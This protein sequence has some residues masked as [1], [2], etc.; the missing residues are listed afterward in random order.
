[1]HDGGAVHGCIKY[2]RVGREPLG[3]GV[4][5]CAIQRDLRERRRDIFV[6][7]LPPGEYGLK[8]GHNTYHDWEV[9]GGKLDES[10]EAIWQLRADP[11]QRAK[12]VTVRAGSESSGVELEL[13]ALQA[14]DD[15]QE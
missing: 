10:S 12:I 15:G 13:P 2:H 5:Q 14:N 7:Q 11:W 8:V 3:R 9:P 6:S 1:M 4:Y